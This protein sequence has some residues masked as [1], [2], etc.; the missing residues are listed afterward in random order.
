MLALHLYG[1]EFADELRELSV[2]EIVWDA[3]EKK[4]WPQ[5]RAGMKLADYVA[6]K[7]GGRI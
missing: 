1:I 2:N 6:L 5:V 3:L 7:R 4:L